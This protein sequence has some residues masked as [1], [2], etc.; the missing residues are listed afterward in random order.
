M[1]T[2]VPAACLITS[3]MM[4]G[5][6][7][8]G[9]SLQK[10]FGWGTRGKNATSPAVDTCIPTHPTVAS[11]LLVDLRTAILRGM[12]GS[13][14]PCFRWLGSPMQRVARASPVACR[15]GLRTSFVVRPSGAPLS[16]SWTVRC[17]HTRAA[18]PAS[19]RWLLRI[20]SSSVRRQAGTGCCQ[21]R[22]RRKK[23]CCISPAHS[24]PFSSMR[25][26]ILS[27]DSMRKWSITGFTS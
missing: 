22:R 10:R 18:S 16:L 7:S 23:R 11:A 1:E 13:T 2:V 20:S 8:S 14:H 24:S 21:S 5:A 17:T 19:A 26:N 9:I 4:S 12:H 6:R 27:F 15:A 25:P 3:F